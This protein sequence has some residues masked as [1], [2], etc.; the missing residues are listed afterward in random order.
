MTDYDALRRLHEEAFPAPWSVQEYSNYTGFSINAPEHGCV[1]ERWE[2]A[3]G[4][5]PDDETRAEFRRHNADLIVAMRNALPSL[6]RLQELVAGAGDAE[7]VIT[8]QVRATDGDFAY[9]HEVW[10]WL[11]Q[12]HAAA[13][14][15]NI[16][17]ELQRV[18]ESNSANARLLWDEQDAHDQTRSKLSESEA[19]RAKLEEELA[20]H[21][22]RRFPIQGG[23]S[24]P[25][26]MIAPYEDQAQR[27]HSQSLERLAERGGLSPGEALA[28]M[29]CRSWGTITADYEGHRK[30][31]E[32]RLAER[33]A[34]ADEVRTYRD[35]VETA[36]VNE[37]ERERDLSEALTGDRDNHGWDALLGQVR[38]LADE[39]TKLREIRD[40]AEQTSKARAAFVSTD[41][42]PQLDDELK[43]REAILD[44]ALR[45][46]GKEAS[47]VERLLKH[48]PAD[49]P[50]HVADGVERAITTIVEH[51]GDKGEGAS[52]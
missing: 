19:A 34:L 33:D 14:V 37:A 26:S 12:A 21:K 40:A 48:P 27:N 23:P 32:A 41:Y 2:N 28:V 5:L 9:D 20:R 39:V 4:K 36:H 47:D 52:A 38:A 13:A 7:E 30:A 6:L 10:L 3:E 51:E 42:D 49:V 25:W 31:L 8:A 24:I 46:A 43:R 45:G 50:P 35:A 18:Y 17:A 44:D 16:E 22:E 1:A 11:I 29:E 15:E